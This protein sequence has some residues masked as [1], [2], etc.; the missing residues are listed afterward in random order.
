[1]SNSVCA[2]ANRDE[3]FFWTECMV[4]CHCSLNDLRTDLVLIYLRLCVLSAAG[5]RTQV[6]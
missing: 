2:H 5:V 6:L 3:D 1:M 4:N